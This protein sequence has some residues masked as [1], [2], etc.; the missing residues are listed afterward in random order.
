M[1][2]SP[3]SQIEVAWTSDGGSERSPAAEDQRVSDS[4][5]AGCS[6]DERT[7]EMQ[8]SPASESW[9][10]GLRT[11]SPSGIAPALQRPQRPQRERIGDAE[12]E[13]LRKVIR[14]TLMSELNSGTDLTSRGMYSI[15]C[16]Y[17]LVRKNDLA[18]FT[19]CAY[20]GD[21]CIVFDEKKFPY[22]NYNVDSA[23]LS[24][25]DEQRKGCPSQSGIWRSSSS[26]VCTE[27]REELNVLWKKE[28]KKK[29]GTNG[30]EEKKDGTNDLA[31]A[32]PPPL[33]IADWAICASSCAQDGRPQ[34]DGC[35]WPRHLRA[36]D[37]SL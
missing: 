15:N 29:D 33:C 6:P 11:Q 31:C 7:D 17:V 12:A 28:K 8:G 32:P 1:E 35:R 23:L 18:K 26:E 10:V 24:W 30:P 4:D 27:G 25:P 20:P 13:F 2:S 34:M 5:P 14:E 37:L 3:S 22:V 9:E 19:R 36:I 21:V 16:L